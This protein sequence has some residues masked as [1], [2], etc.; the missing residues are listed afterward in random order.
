[1]RS[2]KRRLKIVKRKKVSWKLIG[3]IVI[4][5]LLS[6]FVYNKYYI[7][8]RID[9]YV[10]GVEIKND[11]YFIPKDV[12][13]E[14]DKQRKLGLLTQI[15]AYR[16]P[17]LMYHYVE[18]VQ[19][20]KD[21]IRISLN[22]PPFILEQQIKT[23]KEAGYTFMTAGDLAYVLEEKKSLPKKPILLTFDDGYRD[24]YTDAYPILKKYNAYATEYVIAGFLDQPNHLLS[25]QLVE[26]SK[27][28]LVE[29]GAHTVTHMWLKDQLFFDVNYQVSESKKILEKKIHKQVISFA[30]PFGAF[31]QQAINA[32]FKA[33]Y[34]T[35]VS[36]VPGIKQ[37][38]TNRFFL[39]RLRPG[40][41]VGEDLLNWL[42]S[43]Y[44][45][46]F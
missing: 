37:S 12:Q 30:Y 38:L 32:V 2:K 9:S 31:D 13:D 11:Q 1:M 45:S 16:V 42:N 8:S 5:L 17:I 7:L 36:T 20:G 41:R 18:Y 23:L 28:G 25:S 19:D 29:I 43:S 40:G 10:N 26:I 33:G 35:S 21:K 3:A 15:P 46:A 39:Y 14:I 6:A 34:F 24:F 4:L 44:F 27:S 22:T